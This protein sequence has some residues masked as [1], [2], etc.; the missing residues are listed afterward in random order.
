MNRRLASALLALGLVAVACGSNPVPSASI[1]ASAGPVVTPSPG[2]SASASSAPVATTMPNPNDSPTPAPTVT[3]FTL[4][5]AAFH[6]DGMIPARFTCDGRDVSPAMAWT[7]TP[8]GTKWLVLIVDDID[9]HNFTHWIAY[10]IAPGTTRLAEGAGAATS[11]LAQGTN[12][13]GKVGWGGPCPPSGKHRY[14][15]TLYALAAPLGLAG[16][17]GAADVHAALDKAEIL[18]KASITASYAR[19]G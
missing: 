19:G 1:S 8:D 13:F 14:V 16:T 12:D 9:A 7:G 2:T 5:T 6:T 15:F 18:G 3:G 10:A 4:T 17:P 11:R